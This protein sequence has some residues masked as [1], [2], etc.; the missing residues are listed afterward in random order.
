MYYFDC[1]LL[2]DDDSFCHLIAEETLG[3]LYICDQI[4]SVTSAKEALVFINDFFKAR[5]KYP[6]LILLDIEMP[7]IDGF[8]FVGNLYQEIS[9]EK[10]DDFIITI[11]SGSSNP[12]YK[13]AML[14][15]GVKYYL[16]KPLTVDKVKHL[17]ESINQA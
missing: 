8:K 5:G 14:T 6:D 13:E 9:Q 16:N 10:K 3:R 4:K 2:I 11:L 7:E 12:E 15:L 17:I 1:I